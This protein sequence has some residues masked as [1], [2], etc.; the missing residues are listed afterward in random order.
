VVVRNNSGAPLGT[1][2]F[3]DVIEELLGKIYDETD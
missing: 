1:I 3:E 2:A